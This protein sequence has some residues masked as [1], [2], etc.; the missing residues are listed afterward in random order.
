MGPYLPLCAFREGLLPPACRRCT[1]WQTTGKER[2]TEE[3]LVEKKRRW[4]TALEHTWGTTGLL[5]EKTNGG[6]EEGHAQPRIIGSINFSPPEALPRLHELSFPCL[7]AESAVVFCLRTEPG[8]GRQLPKRLLHKS[9]AELRS[10][11]V[12]EVFAFAKENRVDALPGEVAEGCRFFPLDFLLANGF[13]VA[14]T[15]GNLVLMRADLRGLIALAA[16][17]EAAVRKLLHNEPA[18]SPAAWSRRLT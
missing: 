7:P 2:L 13:H 16:Q 5:L 18:P 12:K 6:T 8:A 1:W 9:L 11:G 17:V 4:M 3:A 10:R 15:N 14:G